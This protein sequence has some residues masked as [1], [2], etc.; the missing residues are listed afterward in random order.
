M[1]TVV[2]I[3]VGC[4]ALSSFDLAARQLW[5]NSLENSLKQA[6]SANKP[7]IIDIYAS[8]CM[9]CRRM[10]SEVYPDPAIQKLTNQFIRVR[11][12]GEKHPDLMTRYT[13]RGFPTMIFLN[14]RGLLIGRLSGY[15]NAGRL[16]KYLNEMLNQARENK[17][18]LEQLKG[19]PWSVYWNYKAGLEQYR[20]GELSAARLHFK[21]AQDR[22]P[23]LKEPK[24]AD[25][26][27]AYDS[28]FNLAV[29]LMDQD[30]Y[31]AAAEQWSYYLGCCVTEQKH[32][33]YAR[34]YRGVTFYYMKD[35]QPAKA[36]LLYAVKRLPGGQDKTGAEKLLSLIEQGD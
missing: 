1:K 35:F 17:K 26:Q 36:D 18:I 3:I 31:K 10:Q 11:L 2:A 22:F 32:R 16:S 30:E 14:S 5:S 23:L 25:I 6:A 21:R 29:V 8:W 28:S 4:L 9:Y 24:E 27:A 34:Y 33:T 12:N 15:Q 13:V 19:D 7:L 20:T